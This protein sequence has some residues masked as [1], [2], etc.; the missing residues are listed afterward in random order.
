M[1]VRVRD[2]EMLADKWAIGYMISFISLPSNSHRCSADVVRL[3]ILMPK[4]VLFLSSFRLVFRV[5]AETSV[6]CTLPII[7]AVRH[8]SADD[9]RRG[10]CD[11]NPQFFKLPFNFYSAARRQVRNGTRSSKQVMSLPSRCHFI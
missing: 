11:L 3:R 9:G 10:G 5:F 8:T 7:E 1:G 2:R 6:L 4:L